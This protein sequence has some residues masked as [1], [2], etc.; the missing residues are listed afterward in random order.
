MDFVTDPRRDAHATFAGFV[1]QVNVTILR[2]LKL[3]PTQ[4]LELEAGEDID[5]IQRAADSDSNDVRSL[6]QVKQLRKRRLTLRGGDALESVSNF[7]EHRRVNPGEYLTF[8]F[9][10]TTDVGRERG[11]TAG[12][13]AI[14]TWEQ[15]RTGQLEGDERAAAIAAIH[16]LLVSCRRP[17]AVSKSSWEF[18]RTVLSRS[19]QGELAE[20]ITSFEWATGSGDHA[21]IEAN[22]L[23]VLEK[24]EPPRSPE[25][26]RRVYRDLFAFVFRLL[27]TSGKKSLTT[28][29][30]VAEI[31]SSTLTPKDLLAAA[32]LREWIDHVNSALE[33]HEEDIEEL[34]GR[35]PAERAKTFYEPETSSE[36]SSKT[37]PLF[38][39]NQTLRGRQTRLSDLD[40]FL[41]DLALRIAILPGRGGI[42]KTKLLRD[43]SRGKAGWKI[44]WVSQHGVWHEGTVAEIPAAD[45]VIVADDAH[46]Y[47]NLD[48]LISFVSSWP[49]APRL[50]LIIATRP[51]GQAYVDE[52]L[53]RLADESFIVRYK[54]LRAL[55]KGAA[56][57]IA[58]EML[59]S[60]YE[61]LS[62]RLAE[63]S[64]DTPLITVVGGKLIARGQITPDLLANDREFRQ[65]VFTKFAEDCTGP[66]P[67]GGRSKS[68]LL[69]LIAAVQP[70]EDQG[71]KFVARASV[72]LSLRPDQIRRGLRALEQTE[73]LIRGGGRLRIVPDLFAD[74]LLETASIDGNGRANGFA[75]D[76]FVAFEESH[77]SNVL[78]NFAEL[79]WRI[80]QNGNESRLLERIWSS[81]WARFRSQNALERRHFLREVTDIAVFQPVN[82]QTLIQIA[83][84]EEAQPVKQWGYRTT[85]LHI[86]AELPALLGIT[87]FNERT[88]VDA[89]DRLWRLAQH[90]S[91][92]VSGPAQRTLKEAIGYRKYKHVIFNERILALV[93]KRAEDI[94]SYQGKFTPLSLMDELLDREV[95]TTE[96]KGR[97]FSISALP[98]NYGTIKALRE[99]ALLIIDHALYAQEPRIAVRAAGSLGSILAE[100]HPKFRSGVTEEERVW[101]DSERLDTLE[102]LRKRLEAGNVPLQLAWKVNRILTSIDKRA[103]LSS[104]V[105]NAAAAL[106]LH[107]KRPEHFDF[108]DVLCT[109]EYEDNTEADG[110]ILPTLKR[111]EQQ[112][113]AI[114]SLRKKFPQVEDQIGAVEQFLAQALDAAINPESVDSVLSQMCGDGIFLEG[115]SEHALRH[116][117]SLLASVVGI[118][119]RQWRYAD[120]TQYA[121]YGCLFARSP[122]VRIARSV[123]DVVS[124]GPPLSEPTHQDVEILTALAQR[125]EPYVLESVLIGLKRLPKANAFRDRALALITGVEIGNHH[126]LA[127]EYCNIFGPYGISAALL[128]RAGVE[129]MLA[130]LIGVD[131]LDRDAFGG[132]VANVC[133]I[134]PLAIASFFEARISHAQ[135]LEDNG[136]DTDYEPIPSS[137]SWSTL[138]A[139]R[140]SSDYET[141][142]RN[143]RDLIKRVPEHAF[144][145][146]S[147]FWHIGTT[148]TPTFSVLDELLHTS[149]PDDLEW[150]IRLLADAPKGLALNH[151]M[152]AIHVLTECADR[153]EELKRAAMGRLIGNCFSLGGFQVMTGR[154]VMAGRSGELSDAVQASAAALLANCGSGSLA[155]QLYTEI[156]NARG[157]SFPQPTFPD[158]LDELEDL[159]EP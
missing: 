111:R 23:T 1:F 102:L 153:G 46:H 39:F 65:I 29:I 47:G 122:N 15:V 159:D 31:R 74:Y 44:L 99:R 69:E 12:A 56:I 104:A 93:E 96:W 108:F 49:G 72:F 89:F 101:Q 117:V 137:F 127:K 2:W 81:I 21:A 76:V 140:G 138:S 87:I 112:N 132:F 45:T 141:A 3:Q 22:V 27:C 67:S 71:D 133:G 116:D 144:H 136:E 4:H 139:V 100:Y 95:D 13:S 35:I 107:L 78:K 121:R 125:K 55:N 131:E 34:K 115:F 97:S 106:L 9:L 41:N 129:K 60:E 154:S 84:D 68:E 82:V 134:A 123:A 64:K 10:T 40:R 79:D 58:K 109:N 33:R 98:V 83:M 54:T 62:E 30:L 32:K 43:W 156:A 73:V 66:L 118:A 126:H 24:S 152:F 119:V 105:L 85:Q 70:V 114:T 48:K 142:L 28:D 150:L 145:L 7:C 77:L 90:E 26:A 53:A 36:H 8:R 157:T 14:E 63:V 103:A 92:D 158:D 59:G 124:Y 135:M 143:L 149:D 148:D 130:N 57:E 147:I 113:S 86:L 94:T 110:F 151:P 18:L 19:D 128:D 16:K 5:V 52:M 80:T 20:I 91:E 11:W 75:D 51:S 42:G 155:F 61:H 37:G 6:E 38:D 88:S 120:A 25:I 146:A 50:K 17:K